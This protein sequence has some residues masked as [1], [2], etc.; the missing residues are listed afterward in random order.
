MKARNLRYNRYDR[1]LYKVINGEKIYVNHENFVA[2][3]NPE[4]ELNGN[5]LGSEWAFMVTLV[6]EM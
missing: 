4:I 6:H 2:L 5:K 3:A 1:R